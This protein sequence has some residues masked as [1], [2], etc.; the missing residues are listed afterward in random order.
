MKNVKLSGV[1][2][3]LSLFITCIVSAQQG[4]NLDDHVL[5]KMSQQSVFET[6][7][8]EGSPYSSET[9]INGD[10]YTFGGMYKDVPLR[11]NIYRNNVEF[12]KNNQVYILD[13]GVQIN[14][15]TLDKHTL[16]VQKYPFRGAVKFGF[17]N[18]LD[19]GKVTLLS[20]YVVSYRQSQ[21]PKALETE[22]KPALYSR[23]PDIFYLK[24]GDGEVNEIT[25]LKTLIR[26]FPDK[27]N[28]LNEFAD[29]EKISTRKEDNLIKLV[30]Y[31][32][33]L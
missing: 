20:R 3:F 29:K 23:L 12:K 4:R 31:Y 21:P 11:Y 22:G 5:I 25:N 24:V 18:L 8:Y 7:V 33:S 17:L 1:V 27:H 13:P 15:I 26:Q 6:E 19:S 32:N 14:K 28:E 9:F 10:V 2:F 16:I 30:R